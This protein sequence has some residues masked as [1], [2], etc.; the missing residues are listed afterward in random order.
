[1]TKNPNLQ[2][3]AMFVNDPFVKLRFETYR[4]LLEPCLK[5]GVKI[6]DIGGYQADLLTLLPQDVSYYVADFD[7]EAL[8]I[9]KKR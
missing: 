2:Y 7:K 4:K 6:L 3:G 8:A 1:M 9:A 5:K